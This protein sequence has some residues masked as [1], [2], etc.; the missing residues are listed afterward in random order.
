MA[1]EHGPPPT[2]ITVRPEV[3]LEMAPLHP[4]FL[5]SYVDLAIRG[6]LEYSVNQGVYLSPWWELPEPS[7]A[8][9]RGWKRAVLRRNPHGGADHWGHLFLLCHEGVGRAELESEEMA[10]VGGRERTQLIEIPL[11]VGRPEVTLVLRPTYEETREELH[12]FAR[13]IVERFRLQLD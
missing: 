7:R 12:R 8:P 2:T 4:E 11:R 13:D 10:L 3:A 6:A 9:V 1:E 5:L